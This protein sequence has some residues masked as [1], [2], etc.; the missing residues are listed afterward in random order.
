MNDVQQRARFVEGD[1]YGG[2]GDEQFDL[3]I[4]NPPL[5]PFPDDLGYPMVGCGGDDG[6]KITW[7]ILSGLPHH[8]TSR[9]YAQIIGTTISDGIM[10][11]T[12]DRL[13]DL[14]KQFGLDILMTTVGQRPLTPGTAFFDGLTHTAAAASDRDVDAVRKRYETT[15]HEQGANHLVAYCLLVRKGDGGLML[16]DLHA[17]DN[18][19]FWYVLG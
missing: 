17:D 9:G 15:L 2:I 8:L 3:V 5:L 19:G 11:L 6:M 4:S 7:R 14:A 18:R 1:L 12:F 13:S 10:P 16:Q